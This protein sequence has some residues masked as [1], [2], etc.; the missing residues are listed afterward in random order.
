[1]ARAAEEAGAGAVLLFPPYL[2]ASEQAGLARICRSGLPGGLDRRHRL[3]P[4]QRRARA[5]HGASPRRDLPEPDRAQGRHRRLRGAD[6]AEAARRRPA[7]R[8]QRR[9]DR[10]DDRAAMLRDRHPQL[11]VG[12]LHLPSADS[13]RDISRAVRDDDRATVDRLLREFYMPLSAIRS[14][15]SGYAVSIVKAGLRIVGRPAGP[16]APAADRTLRKPRRAE[17]AALIERAVRMADEPLR[18]ARRSRPGQ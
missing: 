14:R 11:H 4:R 10:R 5:R 13:R 6:D 12:R 2:V 3:Q 1:M 18:H 16:R 8:D 15:R 17:L 9:A 7:G